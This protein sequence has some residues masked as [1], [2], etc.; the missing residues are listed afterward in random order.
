MARRY[1]WMIAL[2]REDSICSLGITALGFDSPTHLYNSG[3]LCE[4]MYTETK[5][6][7]A[8]SEA[9]VDKFVPGEYQALLVAPLDRATFEPDVVVR[10]REPGPG[11]AADAGGAL[12]ARR[13]ARVVVPGPDRLRRHHRDD[14]ADGR[15]PGDPPLLGR[16]DL[17]PDP[18][19]RDGLRDPVGADAGDRRGARGHARGRHPLPDHA[20]HGVRGQAAP[21]VHGGEPA[22]G[23]GARQGRRTRA[24][25]A[26]WPP[27]SA[28]FADRVPVY[29]IVASFAGTLDG[30][31]HRGVLHQS[32]QGHQG[33]AE[34]LRALPAGRGA[35]LQR[36][37]QGGGGL[38][39]PRQVLGLRRARP[40][41]AHV[42]Q[43]D[44]GAARAAWRCPT[45]TR[46]RGCRGSSSSARRWSK[47]K[48]PTA[49]GA[50]AVGPWTIAMLLRNPEMMLLD[51]F[52]DP[53][54]IHDLMRFATD[55]C[56]RWGDAIVKTKIG[57]SLL[58]AHRL[59]QPDLPGQLPGVHRAVPQG[60]GG[61]LQGQEGRASRP[62]SA[63]PP[64]R[65]TRT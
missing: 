63:G 9:A 27:T 32:V 31:S 34:L 16:P 13:P 14:D 62:T 42:L 38:R 36:P 47:A 23:R 64:T 65:S 26:W 44:K 48:L 55:F 12:E 5:E 19:P 7:G 24:A 37:R 29:P 10:L 43:E 61:P 3:T 39:L 25:T 17:R 35:R 53:Q 2:T 22:L 40:S 46:T 30:L 60:A 49:I 11:D 52:E 51:T 58:R 18:G 45:P 54:F 8:R 6:A 20:V 15:A 56:K 50:V 41:R 57:L 1:G 59:H 28:R 33:D 21:E 4:G